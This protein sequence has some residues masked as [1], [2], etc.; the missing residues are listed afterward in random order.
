[1][2]L[3]V[4]ERFCSFR[5]TKLECS[6]HES[7]VF[8]ICS[9]MDNFYVNA[10]YRNPGHESSLY[11]CLLDSVAGYSQLMKKKS[12]PSSVM[13]MLNTLSGWSL[14]LLLIS[15]CV[16]LLIFAICQVVGSWFAVLLTLL[17]TNSI[18][19]CG[20][21]LHSRCVRWYTNGNFRSLLCQLCASDRAI[22]TRVQYQKY[23]LSEASYQ[24]GQCPL[25]TRT[26][27]V[28]SFTRSTNLKAAD[29]L[30]AFDRAIGEVIGMLVPS[31][32]GDAK[33][34]AYH[35]WCRASSSDHRGRFVLAPTLYTI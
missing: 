1:M 22:C 34:T 8:R 6:C 11:D 23:C 25:P 5:Q 29:L 33:Q 26:M 10:L 35:A 4:R 2:D 21:P 7:C 30:C 3:Y 31:R 14:S 24:L 13:R 20:C 28:R 27:S 12:L 16:I 18:L 17:V 19:W 9:R 15:T 32:S